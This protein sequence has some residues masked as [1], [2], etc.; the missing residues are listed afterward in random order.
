M[1][2]ISDDA[3][4]YEC[5]AQNQI[6]MDKTSAMLIIPGDKRGYRIY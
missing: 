6:G 1:N 4:N 2:F 3:G 5:F